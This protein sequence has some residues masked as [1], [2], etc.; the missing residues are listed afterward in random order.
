MLSSDSGSGS[1][2]GAAAPAGMDWLEKL[3][4]SIDSLEQVLSGSGD[5]A[6]DI[7]ATGGGAM[8]N[9]LVDDDASDDSADDGFGAVPSMGGGGSS[10]AGAVPVSAPAPAVT[11]KGGGLPGFSFSFIDDAESEDDGLTPTAS[12]ALPASAKAALVASPGGS[13]G[14][15]PLAAAADFGDSFSFNSTASAMGAEEMLSPQR[16]AA[17]AAAAADG[18]AGGEPPALNG[19]D[20]SSDGSPPKQMNE[21]RGLGS[22]PA[23]TSKSKKAEAAPYD[24]VTPHGMSTQPGAG[25]SKLG[26]G[27]LK[28]G[29]STPW[30]SM[31]LGATTAAAELEED[32][33]ESFS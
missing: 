4:G 15:A 10:A 23:A 17:E 19:L 16:R 9:A 14:P 31:G 18:S 22:L 24:T 33:L 28:G 6:A 5:S 8:L 2:S 11:S 29:A 20:S 27:Q 32:E 3:T 30:A 12:G 13:G 25:G 1:G 7:S 26:G 21:Y